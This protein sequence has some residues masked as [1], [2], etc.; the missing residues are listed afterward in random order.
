MVGTIYKGLWA[1]F[2]TGVAVIWAA[3]LLTNLAVVVLGMIAFGLIYFGMMMVLPFSIQHAEEAVQT[4][5]FG[6]AEI[7]NRVGE[8]WTSPDA[9]MRELK[10][11]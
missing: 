10:Y 5:K 9:A 7:W 2:L 1:I 6:F 3:G 11:H 8:K 4:P